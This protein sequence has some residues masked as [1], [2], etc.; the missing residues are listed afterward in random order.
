MGVVAAVKDSPRPAEYLTAY[1]PRAS[2]DA[3]NAQDEL[4]RGY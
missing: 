2:G 1:H 3:A 4:R